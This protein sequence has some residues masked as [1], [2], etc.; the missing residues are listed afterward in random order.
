MSSIYFQTEM[1]QGYI[2]DEMAET[3]TK[4]GEA[5]HS[6]VLK[7]LQEPVRGGQA[8]FILKSRVSLGDDFMVETTSSIVDISLG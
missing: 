7:V 6:P 8:A 5:F 4:V 3:L 2:Y 1:G